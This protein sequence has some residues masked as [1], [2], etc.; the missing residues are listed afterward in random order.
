M[1]SNPCM[2]MIKCMEN[3]I[4]GSHVSFH[5]VYGWIIRGFHNLF[6]I[7]SWDD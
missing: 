2:T 5:E 4:L 6:E 3:K 1:D 7:S